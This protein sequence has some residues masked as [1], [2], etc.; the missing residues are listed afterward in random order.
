[1]IVMALTA[2]YIIVV[3]L[4]LL[5]AWRVL[6]PGGLL[7]VAFGSHFFADKALAGWTTR[8]MQQ[9][10]ELVTRCGRHRPGR[11]SPHHCSAVVEVLCIAAA[12]GSASNTQV[13]QCS[14]RPSSV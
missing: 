14:D 7:L 3:L 1:M 11:F 2:C 10:N 6:R 5:Q 4:R 13:K 12:S 8:N 9:R